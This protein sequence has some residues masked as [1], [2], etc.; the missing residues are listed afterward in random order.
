MRKQCVSSLIL[1]ADDNHVYLTEQHQTYVTDFLR[2]AAAHFLCD[3]EFMAATR[4]PVGGRIG[5][6]NPPLK[7]GC[8]PSPDPLCCGGGHLLGPSPDPLC[9]GGGHLLR[10]WPGPAWC[11][12]GHLLRPWPGPAWC[13]TG[14]LLG[15]WP[16]PAWCGT[17]RLL[18]PWPGPAWC[19]SGRLLGPW[20]GPGWCGTGRLLGP[21]PGPAWCGTGRLLGPWPGPAWCCSGRLLGP[22]PGPP[23]C[24]TGILLAIWCR[25]GRLPSYD[26]LGSF[27]RAF[28]HAWKSGY[29]GV[30]GEF[31]RIQ[32]CGT[33]KFIHFC[34]LDKVYK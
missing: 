4:V 25:G 10:P 30:G 8:D 1:Y 21:W 14:R 2:P 26:P 31:C 7:S 33:E 16:G 11:G 20:P 3:S 23:W 32:M 34:T 29:G 6:R 12:S 22:W 17:G 9:C 13:G 27:P 15:P 18:G 28:I 19:G 24:G 5:G